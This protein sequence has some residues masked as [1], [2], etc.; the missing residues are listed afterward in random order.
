MWS[1]WLVFCD[2]GFHS[3]CPLMEKNK[4]HMEASCW[5]RLRGKLGLV[6][7]GRAMLSKSLIQF[8][9]DG[10]SRVPSL[11]FTWDQ[12]M[13]DVM[14]IME[15]PFKRS[16]AHTTVFSAPNPAAGHHQP[17]PPVTSK[18]RC[19][20]CFGSISSLFLELFLHWSPAVYWALT[21]LGSS[22]FSVLS[23]CLFILFMGFSTQDLWSGLP[24]PSPADDVLSELS[25]MTRPSWAVLHPWLIVSLS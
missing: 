6:L 21:H 17:M 10:W 4:K 19:C 18:T 24:F 2:C 13:V 25:T 1:D 20:F 5:E 15:T 11:L 9:V 14:K 8:S 23:F 16:H 3:F 12:T 22:S 7:M